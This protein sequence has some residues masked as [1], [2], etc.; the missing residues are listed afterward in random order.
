MNR[1]FRIKSDQCMKVLK[2]SLQF[3]GQPQCLAAAEACLHVERIGCEPT[4]PVS[5]GK[6][7]FAKL[8]VR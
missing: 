2:G 7:A 8:V 3:P 6:F 4:I 5:N 1:T